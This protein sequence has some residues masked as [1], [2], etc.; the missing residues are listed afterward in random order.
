MKNN[1]FVDLI[2]L[3]LL[4]LYASTNLYNF[5]QGCNCEKVNFRES[6]IKFFAAYS[7]VMKAKSN[8]CKTNVLDL[9][10]ISVIPRHRTT[11]TK[12][13]SWTLAMTDNKTATGM[14]RVHCESTDAHYNDQQCY[15]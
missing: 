1:S 12:T 14:K 10:L 9:A 2:R 4:L 11:E 7:L 3:I 15:F 5:C 6:V 13:N 8:D